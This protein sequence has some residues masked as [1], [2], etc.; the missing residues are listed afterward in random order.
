MSC[1]VFIVSRN[2][3]QDRGSTGPLVAESISLL[4]V[5]RNQ[6]SFLRSTVLQRTRRHTPPIDHLNDQAILY[7]LVLQFFEH[8]AYCNGRPLAVSIGRRSGEKVADM[9]LSDLA[10]A[11]LGELRQCLADPYAQRLSINH[12]VFSEARQHRP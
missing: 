4:V 12:S 5:L 11:L 7:S 10:T 2:R 6:F 3:T 8:L 9:S 1:L